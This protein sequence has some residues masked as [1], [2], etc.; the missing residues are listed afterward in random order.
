MIQAAERTFSY[1]LSQHTART[2]QLHLMHMRTARTV[3]LA[4]KMADNNSED[5]TSAKYIVYR[6]L[7]PYQILG[8]KVGSIY[9]IYPGG[10]VR[11]IPFKHAHL[12]MRITRAQRVIACTL[13]AINLR[14]RVNCA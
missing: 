6:S 12:C 11:V 3:R 13:R 5:V 14:V 9:C 2:M 7:G 1:L 10:K 8:H 4:N